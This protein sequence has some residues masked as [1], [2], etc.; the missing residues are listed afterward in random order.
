MIDTPE[1]QTARLRLR[2]PSQADFPAEATFL[3]S[4]RARFVGGPMNSEEA[5]R[6]L[7]MILGHWALRG[8]G[9]F[10][11]EE[12][13]TGTYCGRV[14]PWF[15]E[16]WPEPEIGWTVSAGAEGRGIAREAAEAARCHAYDTLGWPTA[17]SLIDPANTRSIAL[18]E[19]LGCHYERDFR[20][21]RYGRIGVWRHPAPEA[22]Q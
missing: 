15:P 12:R 19:R 17:I 22:L 11:V 9:F 18:A 1:I 21:V 8:Y 10:A 3:A 7:A 4:E 13:D 6:S 14:G 20:H 16:G 5:W 2:P